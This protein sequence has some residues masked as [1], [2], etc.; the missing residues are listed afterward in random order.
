MDAKET[1]AREVSE[2]LVK[3]E[4]TPIVKESDLT[5]EIIY[6]Q[7]SLSRSLEMRAGLYQTLLTYIKQI[8]PSEI[9]LEVSK[10]F[11]S[12]LAS[13][14]EGFVRVLR[15]DNAQAIKDAQALELEE[16]RKTLADAKDKIIVLLTEQ[17]KDRAKIARME[18][19]LKFLPDLQSQA[20]RALALV[21]GAGNLQEELIRLRVELNNAHLSRVRS[22]LHRDHGQ[23]NWWS[24]VRAHLR[25]IASDR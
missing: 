12:E 21:N 10:S 19:E 9:N 5:T 7:L 16:L 22:K 15:G 18:T 8:S 25:V 14:L 6:Q 4:S 20:D 13:V 23:R 1:I 3:V 17:G 24:R 11:K 2:Q